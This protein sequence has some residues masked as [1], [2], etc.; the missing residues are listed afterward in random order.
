MSTARPFYGM[1]SSSPNLSTSCDTQYPQ[2][3]V[4]KPSR[5]SVAKSSGTDSSPEI[6]DT[7]SQSPDQSKSVDK[8]DSIEMAV[9][10]TSHGNRSIDDVLN[11]SHDD[12]EVSV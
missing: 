7:T 12:S 2:H 1:T 5:F 8:A 10:K 9:R 4:S 11:L 3:S 6:H